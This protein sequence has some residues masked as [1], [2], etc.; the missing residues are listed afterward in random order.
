MQPSTAA[1]RQRGFGFLQARCSDVGG[2]AAPQELLFPNGALVGDAFHQTLLIVRVGQGCFSFAY[3]GLRRQNLLSSRRLLQPCQ[4]C[5]DDLQIA[6]AEHHFG[7]QITVVER[8]EWRTS[9]HVVANLDLHGNDQTGHGR[10]DG[11]IF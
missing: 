5:A 4:P 2:F 11:D 8:K 7:A 9:A 6:L 10:T 3:F 1:Q